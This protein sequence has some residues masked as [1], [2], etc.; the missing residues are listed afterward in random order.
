MYQCSVYLDLL[1]EIFEKAMTV[2]A[3]T[4]YFLTRPDILFV[5]VLTNEHDL[6]GIQYAST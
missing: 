2:K 6:V 4:G 3:M 1:F 5:A